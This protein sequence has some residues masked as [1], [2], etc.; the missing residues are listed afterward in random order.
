MPRWFSVFL[1]AACLAGACLVTGKYQV[2]GDTLWHLKAGEW[3]VA[4]GAVPKADPFS[5][6]AGGKPWHAHEWLWEVLA[7]GASCLGGKWGVW[8]LTCAGALL[9]GG[10]LFHLTRR[11]GTLGVCLAGFALLCASPFWDARPHSLAQGL[12]ALWVCLLSGVVSRKGWKAGLPAGLS[13]AALW[14][15]LHASAVMAPLSALLFALPPGPRGER[16][17]YLGAAAGAALGACLNPWGAGIYPYALAASRAPDVVD[18]IGEWSSPDF[19]NS[20]FLLSFLVLFA[21]ALLGV[22][23]RAR[24]GSGL[25][26]AHLF[27]A[28]TSVM[29][30]VS[31]RHMP[32]FYFAAAWAASRDLLPLYLRAA[33]G[34]VAAAALSLVAALVAATTLAAGAAHFPP[35]WTEDPRAHLPFPEGAVDFML[36]RGLTER[37][38]NYYG[39]GGYLVYR[40]VRPFV[41]GRADM[42][43]LSGSGV[44]RDYFRAS[45]GLKGGRWEPCDP[46]GVMEK[47]GV[48][49]V[50]VPRGSLPELALEGRGWEAVYRDD[51]SVLL[52]RDR[53]RR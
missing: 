28:L 40:G 16:L 52:V 39:W 23:C 25:R 43:V 9:W 17:G 2:E 4:H 36:E 29:A 44:F 22:L 33:S 30:L 1:V 19:H 6:T 14:A 32:Y 51:F 24:E 50:L 3:I 18:H 20:F 46:L 31:V 53:E 8:A 12:W 41:D 49:A 21:P 45:G 26:P 35:S 47:W 42:Y 38:F 27:L 10:S 37:V 15:N 7:Y 48:E 5:W 11:S 13:L 34:R